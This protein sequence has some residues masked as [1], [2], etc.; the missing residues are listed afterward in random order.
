M[1]AKQV[2]G[3]GVIGPNDTGGTSVISALWVD[4]QPWASVIVTLYSP[5]VN[6]VIEDPVND[7]LFCNKVGVGDDHK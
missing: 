7:T 5:A 6:P 3:V 1:G 2:G 4:T